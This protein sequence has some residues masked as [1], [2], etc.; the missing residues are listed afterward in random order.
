MES[1]HD[2]IQEFADINLYEVLGIPENATISQIKKRYNKLVLKYHPDKIKN[3]T[4]KTNEKF[5]LISEAYKILSVEKNR[6]MYDRFR[7]IIQENT[8]DHTSLK[9]SYKEFVK[10]IIVDK[11]DPSYDQ[12]KE[13]GK[14]DFDKKWEELNKKHGV[15]TDISPLSTKEADTRLAEMIKN[16]DDGIPAHENLFEN[17]E[18]NPVDFNK[19]FEEMKRKTTGK[20]LT[21]VK[22]D[23]MDSMIPY[24][25][26][27]D[28]N[29]YASGMDSRATNCAGIN[30]AFNLPS[31]QITAK[32]MDE[33]TS[34]TDYDTH[35]K[36]K[37]DMKT[38]EERMKEYDKMT[39]Q[40]NKRTLKDFSKDDYG[41]Y[42]IFDKLLLDGSSNKDKVPEKD[43][44]DEQ[45][46]DLDETANYIDFGDTK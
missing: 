10:D 30:E 45:F 14:Q 40:F 25:S 37:L 22:V 29:L 34:T 17:K 38:L 28:S 42:G 9:S 7:E 8:K 12:K 26:I 1:I 24:A 18:F 44:T 35:D 11:D 41:D 43:E 5:G 36:D 4:D 39:K 46:D 20:E 19:E 33:I 21:T 6:K 15:S 2:K 3:P 13:E 31:S 16:R 23:A 32:D 27:Y